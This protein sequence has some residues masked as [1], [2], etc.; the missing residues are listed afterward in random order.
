MST[1]RKFLITTLYVT[2]VAAIAV[3]GNA[4]ARPHEAPPYA[5]EIKD[6]AFSPRTLTIP[7]GAKVTWTNKDE[8]PHK[9]VEVNTTFTS[10]PLDTD[11][12]FTY[13]FNTP[14]T[15]EYFCALHPRMTGKI[16]VQK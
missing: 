4:A 16:I 15:Y 8:E 13:Q 1:L 11:G 14:G 12:N 6:F 5:I 7:V 9:V 10:Q 2:A 3:A